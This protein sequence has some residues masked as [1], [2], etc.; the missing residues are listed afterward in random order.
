M[1][2]LMF[3]QDKILILGMLSA[4]LLVSFYVAS[5]GFTQKALAQNTTSNASGSKMTTIS[6]ATNATKSPSLQGKE[7]PGTMAAKNMSTGATAANMT[8]ANAT[9]K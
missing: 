1:F 3:K 4:V 6:N 2:D 8:S 9:G 5:V 7:T